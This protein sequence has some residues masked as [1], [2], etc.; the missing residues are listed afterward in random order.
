MDAARVFRLALE[1]GARG[2]AFHAVAEGVPFRLVA[3][4][5][6]RQVGVPARSLTPAEAERH[7]GGLAIWVTGSG[8][9]SNER[10]V[11]I[12]GWEPKEIGIISDV[13]RPQYYI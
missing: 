10:T 7:F 13:D 11:A 5:I 4:A 8:H 6:G 12:L 1:R 3:E 9:V 2:E